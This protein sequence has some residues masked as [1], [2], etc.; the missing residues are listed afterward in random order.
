MHRRDLL[1]YCASALAGVT[2]P[3]PAFSAEAG[4]PGYKCLVNIFLFGG[5]DAFNL[6]VPRSD[7]EYN[8]YAT[9]R[10]NLAV[11]QADLLAISPN[12]PDGASYGFH[13]SATSLQTLFETGD[14]AI[15]ANTGPLIE[16]TTKD[17]YLA[18]SVALPPQLFS[19]NDQQDQWHTLKGKSPLN[20]GWA[21]RIADLMQNSTQDQLLALNTSIAGTT[22]FQAGATST[23]YTVSVNGANTYGAL[24]QGAQLGGARRTAFEAYL[25]RGF[26]NLHARAL[27][28]VHQRSLN[29]ADKVN[30][31]LALVPQLT[32]PFPESSLGQQLNIIARLIAVKDQFAMSRQIFFAATGGFDTHDDQNQLQPGLIQNL[33]DSIGAFNAAL[34]E[35]GQG[36]NV[37]TST[38]SDFGRTLTS[39]GDG[40]DHGWGSHQIVTGA[41][42][43][44]R[45]IYGNMPILEIGGEND[46]TGGR[47][48]PTTSADQYAATL[49][50]W[51]GIGAEDMD[52]VAPNLSN[53]TSKNLGFLG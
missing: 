2:L 16:P 30:Q 47:I 9:S 42:V 12:N 32:T 11:P 52:L 8:T 5:N 53:F 36:E 37:V 29:T 35:I 40:T 22:L 6:V 4:T 44:G 17:A 1:R 25:D 28:E 50:S 13:P 39:N 38:Q 34:A 21:G 18:Q 27:A 41:S 45:R 24:D 3:F 46:A 20:T 31:A 14:L 26:T 51:F 49:A 43:L 19:H 10:Q 7:A 23:P 15:I 33:S 48:I